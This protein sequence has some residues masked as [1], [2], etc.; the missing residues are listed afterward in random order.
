M[1]VITARVKVNAIFPLTL[2][3]F[4]TELDQKYC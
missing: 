2:A 1:K 3:P 4:N